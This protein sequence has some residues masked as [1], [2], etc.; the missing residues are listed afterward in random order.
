MNF[1]AVVGK[2][3]GCDFDTIQQALD[4]VEEGSTIQVKPGAYNEHLVF[5]KKVRLVGCSESIENKA[6]AELPVVVLDSDKACKIDVPVEITG[7]VFTHKKDLHFDS[8]SSFM[9]LPFEGTEPE[10]PTQLM[11]V[12]SESS[13]ANIAILCAE[14]GYGIEFSGAKAGFEASFVYHTYLAG[15][16]IANDAEPTISNC[17]VS[18]SNIGIVV[19]GSAA[20]RINSCTIEKIKTM[21]IASAENANPYVKSCEIKDVEMV[22]VAAHDS[23]TGLYENCNVHHNVCGF[24]FNDASSP[25]I[26]EC[27]VHNNAM[28]ITCSNEAKPVV[29]DCEIFA[30]SGNGITASGNSSP[31]ITKC[32]IYDNNDGAGLASS[33]TSSPVVRLC[34]IHNCDP[35]IIITQE[36]QGGVFEKCV[37]YDC[38]KFGVLLKGE[39]LNEGKIRATV[40]NC[41]ICGCKTGVWVGGTV[42]EIRETEVCDNS[43]I[44]INITSELTGI[45]ENCDIHG[46]RMGIGIFLPNKSNFDT[47]TVRDNSEE[48]IAYVF[49]NLMNAISGQQK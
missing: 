28:G 17:R 11:L 20:P 32:Q 14:G 5:K 10:S 42:L 9:E 8:L 44:G 22:A 30:S 38:G 16:R 3:G 15:I 19:L 39:S 4:S 37:V 29:E 2:D 33:G 43:D 35:G 34:E 45:Y 46:N 26:T 25:R 27:T 13:L 49:D 47:C 1:T 21:G 18:G 24:S 7:M 36:S 23:A 48:N 31:K 6:S 40:K 12:S 41:K